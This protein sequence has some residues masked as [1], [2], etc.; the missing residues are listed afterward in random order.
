MVDHTLKTNYY[1]KN[2]T[3]FSFSLDPAYLDFLPFDRKEKFPELPYAIF[4]MK[5]LYFLGFHIRF[6]DLRAAGCAP[7]SPKEWNR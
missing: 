2:K 5:G 3:A 1:R 7:Y 6:R 4:F